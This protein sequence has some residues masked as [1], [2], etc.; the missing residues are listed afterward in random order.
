VIGF[1]LEGKAEVLK[2]DNSNTRL[3]LIFEGDCNLKCDQMNLENS[4][5]CGAVSFETLEKPQFQQVFERINR[6]LTLI[7]VHLKQNLTLSPTE[8]PSNVSASLGL[9]PRAEAFSPVGRKLLHH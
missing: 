3:C 8:L 1:T 5:C 9:M 4:N 6:S 7:H 2:C